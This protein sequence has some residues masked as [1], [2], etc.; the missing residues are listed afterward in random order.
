MTNDQ[1]VRALRAAANTLERQHPVV[2]A[3]RAIN[4]HTFKH[5]NVQ[6]DGADRTA[7]MDALKGLD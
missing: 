4:E 2:E 7:L 6:V 1:L 3:A 5:G